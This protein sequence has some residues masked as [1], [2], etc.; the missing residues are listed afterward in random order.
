[1]TQLQVTSR[2]G[3]GMEFFYKYE[4]TPWLHVTPDNQIFIPARELVDTA[5]VVGVMEL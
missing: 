5:F 3:R 4:V 1:M 2:D